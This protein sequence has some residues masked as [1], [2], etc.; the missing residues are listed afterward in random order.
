MAF[1]DLASL[2]LIFAHHH[3]ECPGRYLNAPV[4]ARATVPSLRG[5]SGRPLRALAALLPEQWPAIR[6]D[7]TGN[8]GDHGRALDPG[9]FLVTDPVIGKHILLLDDTW[10]TGAHS[11]SAAAALRQAGAAR[12]TILPICRLL[13]PD[14]PA[15]RRY[16]ESPHHRMWNADTCPVTGAACP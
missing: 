15:N 16:L 5:N 12:V 13:R 3:R 14:W 4:A 8:L 1:A 2:V 6:L 9:N 11:Q 7:P 10:V